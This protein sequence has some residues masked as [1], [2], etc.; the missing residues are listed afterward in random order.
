MKKL[1]I[2]AAGAVAIGFSAVAADWFNA[3]IGNYTAW[4][5][6]NAAFGGT[7]LNEG[8]A[9]LEAAGVLSVTAQTNAPLTFAA[10]KTNVIDE[11]TSATF[12]SMLEFTAF[13]SDEMPD[14]PKDAKAGAIVVKDG[15]NTLNYY[16][17]ADQAQEGSNVWEKI[18]AV[19]VVEGPV[20]VT[21]K[22]ED[23][24][25]WYY[26]GS[27]DNAADVLYYPGNGELSTTCYAGDGTVKSLSATYEAEPAGPVTFTIADV[28]GA[29]KVVA[30]NGVA[31]AY[32]Y[33]AFAGDALTVTYTAENGKLFK[34]GTNTYVYEGE[35]AEGE[36]DTDV[37]KQGLK[38]ADA[39][40]GDGNL[41]YTLNDALEAAVDGN[42]VVLRRDIT[43]AE[44]A[45][46]V[47]NKS[48][49]LDFGV[50]TVTKTVANDYL[51]DITNGVSVTFYGN[52]GGA[53]QTASN[54]N[55]TSPASMI[56][57]KGNLTIEGGV[58]TSDFCII[59][60]DED[61][62]AGVLT[63]N[64]GTFYMVKTEGGYAGIQMALMNCATATI[65][66]S[67]WD[68]NTIC[69]RSCDGNKV[70]KAGTTTIES[71]NAE[72]MLMVGYP[73][74]TT[75]K[76]FPKLKGD[77]IEIENVVLEKASDCPLDLEL[78]EDD[79]GYITVREK[80]K[81]GPYTPETGGGSVEPVEGEEG[82]YEVQADPSSKIVNI[83]GGLGEDDIIRVTTTEDITVMGVPEDQIEVKINGKVI[84]NGAFV[85][86][87]ADGFSTALNP[88][89]EVE[90][91]EKTIKVT[92]TAT[93]AAASE[94]TIADG[95][96]ATD[97]IPGLTYELKRMANVGDTPASIGDGIKT[98]ATTTSVTLKDTS[99]SKP[100]DKAF[101]VIE[102]TK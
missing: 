25:A 102:V 14:V 11:I 55:P 8:G 49:T 54:L 42:C 80:E 99:A 36:I 59:K 15:D 35:V 21:I 7:W 53:R 86:G 64:G 88:E 26:F 93:E 72:Y 22:L 74:D 23:G 77:D 12:K 30:T 29:T 90:I 38:D 65:N 76:N 40:I 16:V 60:N 87:D 39:Q 44:S 85:G 95:A 33:T 83:E 75:W 18:E 32:P 17:L 28:D 84:P 52:E 91:G 9:T 82:V 94:G 48:I 68:G 31:L 3:D 51:F 66:S 78:Y 73:G 41:Y 62:G 43:T 61:P 1:M 63:V 79:D 58:Y 6:N 46:F 98:T 45:A 47:I 50:Y 96:V 5:T 71:V 37:A 69:T 56:R 101:Y 10:A 70:S 20:E 4:P 24:M 13:P 92:P 34:N 2:A 57:N 27:E 19:K 100:A 89:G 67:N 97:A 81:T